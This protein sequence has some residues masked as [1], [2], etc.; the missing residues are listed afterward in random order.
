MDCQVNS[1]TAAKYLKMLQSTDHKQSSSPW[2]PLF[3]QDFKQVVMGFWDTV[4]W[5]PRSPNETSAVLSY[6]CRYE[7]Q[8][9]VR[10]HMGSDDESFNCISQQ[11]DSEGIRGIKLDKVRTPS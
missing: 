5:V 3:V 1:C 2:T 9:L 6:L 10:T 7:L 8:H 4:L 11:E